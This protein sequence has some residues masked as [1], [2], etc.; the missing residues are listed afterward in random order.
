MTVGNGVQPEVGQVPCNSPPTLLAD[1]AKL[2]RGSSLL[3]LNP[4]PH[5]PCVASSD[6]QHIYLS[7]SLGNTVKNLLPLPTR[8]TPPVP[9]TSLAFSASGDPPKG[10]SSMESSTSN[11]PADGL[12]KLDRREGARLER[13]SPGAGQGSESG[14]TAAEALPDARVPPVLAVLEGGEVFVSVLGTKPRGGSDPCGQTLEAHAVLGGVQKTPW[15]AMAWHPSRRGVLAVMGP[16]Q[17]AVYIDLHIG[18]AAGGRAGPAAVAVATE[19]SLNPA[20]V[21]PGPAAGE[22]GGLAPA[23][24]STTC[25][26]AWG[27][28]G[29]DVLAVSWHGV[30]EL[31]HGGVYPASGRKPC[32][33]PDDVAATLAALGVGGFVTAAAVAAE[34]LGRPAWPFERRPFLLGGSGGAIRA[35]C[36]GPRGSI[37]GT[38]EA[39]VAV[40]RISVACGDS[41]AAGGLDSEPEEA[42]GGLLDLRGRCGGDAPEEGL[43]SGFLSGFL[44]ADPGVG[45]RFGVGSGGVN[46]VEP[47][48]DWAASVCLVLP[49]LGPEAIEAGLGGTGAGSAVC[50]FPLPDI[51][52]VGPSFLPFL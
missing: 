31:F 20:A 47:E 26:L 46:A 41:S 49:P 45:V 15:R 37:V 14:S 1:R 11:V 50:A 30:V 27:G 13:A 16:A 52:A 48:E 17:L 19:A 5:T 4:D 7:K 22:A 24:T 33:A 35:L 12:A 44:L 2:K 34:P 28:P 23:T 42:D 25:A 8:Q 38:I 29:E 10:A 51:L 32:G 39:R 21:F 6:G 40:S 36:P 43:L 9:I 18:L 3:A